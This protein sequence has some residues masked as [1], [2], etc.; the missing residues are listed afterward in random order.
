MTIDLNNYEVT[1]KYIMTWFKANPHIK[2]TDAISQMAVATHCPCIA[3]EF[4]IA[5]EIGF[6]EEL[7]K[8]L[9]S[10]IKNYCYPNILNQPVNSPFREL[11]D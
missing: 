11:C 5:E 7:V 9:N 8:Y 4:F 3:V 6:T 1:K 2:L 10:D